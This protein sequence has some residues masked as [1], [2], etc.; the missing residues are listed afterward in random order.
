M[1]Q[2]PCHIA[3]SVAGRLLLAGAACAASGEGLRWEV[4][5]IASPRFVWAG[6]ESRVRVVIRNAGSEV[7]SSSDTA[8][9]FAYHWLAADGT[10]VQRDGLRTVY[11][12]PVAPGEQIELQARLGPPPGAGVW[13]L[14]WEPVRERGRWLGPPANAPAV[15]H[16][17]RAGERIAVY[18]GGFFAVTVL[19][20]GGGLLL[21]SRPEATWW[22]LLIVPMAWC[23]LGVVVQA[24]G[25]L[26]RTGYGTRPQTF[27]LEVAAATLLTLPVAL[28]PVRIRRWGAAL[29][30][31][32]AAVTAYADVVYFRY[33]GALV[34]LTAAHAAGQT[35]QVADSVRALTGSADGWFAV[36]AAAALVFAL[37]I[38]ATTPRPPTARLA[39]WR[40]FGA[41]IL[42]V[43]LLAWPAVGA[44]KIA[45]TAGD[46]A[47]QVFSHD[48]MLRRWGVGV[49]HLIDVVRTTREQLASRR[50][51][52]ATRARVLAYFRAHQQ[53]TPPPS[54][55]S[56]LAAGMNLLLIQVESLQQWVI[57][58]KVGEQEVTPFL[59]GWRQHAL[60]FP[61]VFDQ[62]NQGRSS[63]GEFIALNSLHV[64]DDGAVA[65]RRAGNRFHALPAV[66]AEAGYSTVSAHAFERGFW[67]RAVL[68]PRF[69]FQT[70]FFRRELGAGEQIGWGLADHV[71]F[72][73][74]LPRLASQSQPFMAFL[75]TLGLHHPFEG[76]PARHR[77]L[78]LADLEGSPLGNYLQAMHYIDD[79]LARL[80]TGLDRAGLAERTVIA[81]YG[82][83]DAGLDPSGPL[84]AVAGWPRRDAS[85]WPRIDRIPLFVYVPGAGDGC[86]GEVAVEGGHLD[87]AP[88][89]LD[90]L[91]VDPPP[92]FLGSSL[93]R[94]RQYPVAAPNGR[95]VGHGVIGAAGQAGWADTEGCWELQG[96]HPLAA[97]SCRPLHAA[98][99][100]ERAISHLVLL[101]DMVEEI[102]RSLAR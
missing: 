62:S 35:A 29:L 52:N 22:Y 88:T 92:A 2:R 33:F 100:E 56:G 44:M 30:V 21:R 79:S 58:A 59:N 24:L 91:G 42:V 3:L 14:E 15:R 81:L 13:I 50:P 74:M 25:F 63:D 18:Q 6:E 26:L 87:I 37:G 46:L 43:A 5:E 93:L 65:F 67:N 16:K 73:R 78:A 102:N 40:G 45:F 19:L 47:T 28:L 61:Y 17:V 31:L 101:H 41:A 83:H 72:E 70:S 51:D 66:L 7:W 82:D 68:H 38:W 34:P 53:A 54:P 94:D 27:S 75:I 77:R 60:Y 8:D 95:A 11:P 9:H 39:R 48:Q 12:R 49:T 64:L 1:A 20:V 99:Q 23:G 36:A 57:G 55:C 76:F 80:V 89:L 86:R 85:T 10:L 96:G 98:A 71:F 97:E 32:F 84:L 69:G 90:L 4:V